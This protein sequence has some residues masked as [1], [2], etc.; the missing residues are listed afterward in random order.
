M[1]NLGREKNVFFRAQPGDY[2]YAIGLLLQWDWCFYNKHPAI[3]LIL[4]FKLFNVKL[5]TEEWLVVL[6]QTIGPMDRFWHLFSYLTIDWIW[7]ALAVSLEWTS[8]HCWLNQPWT[9]STTN[10][11]V[12]TSLPKQSL[13]TCHVCR[14]KASAVQS[15][16]IVWVCLHGD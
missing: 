2:N 16:Y 11:Y 14:N 10:I 1:I 6:S 9:T 15:G 3:F 4:S 5:E 13:V 7:I 12:I 8:W